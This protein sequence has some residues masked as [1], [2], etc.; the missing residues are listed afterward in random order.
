MLTPQEANAIIS[1]MSRAD[2][3]GN[4][5]PTFMACIQKIKSLVDIPR[6]VKEFTEEAPT[7]E[8]PTNN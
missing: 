7:E 1:F 6:P 8:S 5:A 2:L 3:K 4:E